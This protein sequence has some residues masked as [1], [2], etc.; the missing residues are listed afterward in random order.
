MEN[1]KIE[2]DTISSYDIQDSTSKLE[3]N[4]AIEKVTNNKL[5]SVCKIN[6][7]DI[8]KHQ[9]M[10]ISIG[11]IIRYVCFDCIKDKI[12]NKLCGVINA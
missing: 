9:Y 4:D 1:Y 7:I 3:N 12:P 6:E 10:I 2:S 5:C 8:L 11:K